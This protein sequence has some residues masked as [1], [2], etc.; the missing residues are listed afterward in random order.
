[1]SRSSVLKRSEVPGQV[2]YFGLSG[3]TNHHISTSS[4]IICGVI[5]SACASV[6]E[7]LS[8]SLLVSL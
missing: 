4:D 7:G 2:P 1:M 3:G 6:M 5:L 8:L